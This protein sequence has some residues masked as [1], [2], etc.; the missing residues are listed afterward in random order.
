MHTA[1]N[2]LTAWILSAHDALVAAADAAGA[3]PR[4]LAVLTLVGSHPGCTGEWLRARV[5]LTQ[6]GTVR[7][8][9]RL[10]QAGHLC[11]APRAGRQV[12]LTLTAAGAAVVT[13]WLDAR[14][15][16]LA[17]VTKG[18]SSQRR[19]ALVD[20]LTTA[21][22]GRDRARADAD[23]TCRGCDWPACG[24]ACPVDRSVLAAAR[25]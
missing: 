13:A 16:A 2:V 8:L 1:D 4:D 11:R 12:A 9:D 24:D 7:L 22:A 15:A 3:S 14:A 23:A 21:L 6:S 25:R 18:L 5:G 20:V 19:D 10:E 17:E